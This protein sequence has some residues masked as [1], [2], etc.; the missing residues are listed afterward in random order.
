MNYRTNSQETATGSHSSP[1]AACAFR[2]I[3]RTRRQI[4]YAIE[5]AS[6]TST[7]RKVY[8]NSESTLGRALEGGYRERVKI[9][10]K[11]PPYLVKKYADF[12]RIFDAPRT[13]L[14]TDYI[15]LLPSAHADGSEQSGRIRALGFENWVARRRRRAKFETLAFPTT[16]AARSFRS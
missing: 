3:R 12:D 6:T 15:R 16:A 4:L 5:H 2:A 8:P 7:R 14:K 1:T 10:T 9:A 13:R 11:L